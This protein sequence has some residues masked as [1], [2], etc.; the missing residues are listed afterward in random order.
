MDENLHIAIF[1]SNLNYLGFLIGHLQSQGYLDILPATTRESAQNLVNKIVQH[2]ET[3]YLA[4]MSDWIGP[5]VLGDGPKCH[6]ELYLAQ[7]NWLRRGVPVI[8]ISAE[9]RP[10]FSHY[11]GKSENPVQINKII[12]K[13]TRN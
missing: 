2:T 4:F 8:G 11:I 10:W 6:G 5:R 3:P 9:N 13:L 1:E 7:L 12:E